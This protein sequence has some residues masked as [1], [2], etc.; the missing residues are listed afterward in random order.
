M[1]SHSIL[2][3]IAAPSNLLQ[4]RGSLPTL[5]NPALVHIENSNNWQIQYN[6]LYG[7]EFKKYATIE[8]AQTDLYKDN[9]KPDSYDDP[10][11]SRD[12]TSEGS[13]NQV[14]RPLNI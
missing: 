9:G 10:S 4:F 8:P 7:C 3:R 14:V 11:L 2:G 1:Q 5:Q 6:V 13:S 12:A